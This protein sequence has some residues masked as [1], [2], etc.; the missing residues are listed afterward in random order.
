MNLFTRKHNQTIRAL[1]VRNDLLLDYIDGAH[2]GIDLLAGIARQQEDIIVSLAG[3][4]QALRAE[5]TARA[6]ANETLT[7]TI[8]TLQ[9]RLNELD[10]PRKNHAQT[11]QD[12][13][14]P[15]VAAQ[16]T[17]TVVPP[18]QATPAPRRRARSG[19][20]TGSEVQA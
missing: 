2:V 3:D 13:Q 15:P 1:T 16:D 6:D 12:G 19:K 5:C 14:E 20:T 9:A 10:P 11:P 4:V 17:A 18:E 8:A 7:G